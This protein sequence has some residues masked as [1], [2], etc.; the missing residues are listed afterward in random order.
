[1]AEL[2]RLGV[3]DEGLRRRPDRGP[4]A[5][6]RGH[7]PLRLAREPAVGGRLASGVRQLDADRGVLGVREVDDAGPGVPL[8]VVPQP[9]V[10]GADAALGC[11]GRGLGDDQTEATLGSGAQVDQVPVGR[12]AVF[13]LHGVLAHRGQ[14]DPVLHRQVAQGQRFEECGHVRENPVVAVRSS[15]PGSLL[16]HTARMTDRTS[17]RRS[18]ETCDSLVFRD[19]DLPRC[20][21]RLC[22][23]WGLCYRCDACFAPTIDDWSGIHDAETADRPVG[24]PHPRPDRRRRRRGTG[25]G[26]PRPARQ[27][28][29]RQG[30]GGRG[31]DQGRPREGRPRRC[32][33]EGRSGRQGQSRGRREGQGGSRGPDP[34]RPAVRTQGHRSGES[35]R[36]RSR[37][38]RS[39]A[40]PERQPPPAT[41]PWPRPAPRPPPRR[42]LPPRPAPRRW[43]RARHPRSRRPP[44]RRPRR[45]PPRP[46]PR[47]PRPT[48]RRPGPVRTPLGR[49]RAPSGT[50][51]PRPTRPP[52]PG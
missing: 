1:M 9:G 46:P 25:L 38:D 36:G 45:P 48:P 32:S 49:P 4:T 43:P 20:S 24:H 22:N 50:P 23:G 3:T 41:P 19:R 29:H 33:A 47:R 37:G 35:R 16:R 51:W 52:P 34:R 17:S 5:R 8:L 27:E 21:G 11:H 42:R 18:Y 15:A 40:E 14:P 44:P 39:G 30:S 7:T 31:E 6:V 26:R 13:G 2:D 10:L 12:H 28:R